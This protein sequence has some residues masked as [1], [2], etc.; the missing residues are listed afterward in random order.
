MRVPLATLEPLIQS[1]EVV[2]VTAEGGR[3]PENP[4]IQAA[5]GRFALRDPVV[6]DD[7]LDGG[8]FPLKR[9]PEPRSIIN[10][11][12]A[13]ARASGGQCCAQSSRPSADNQYVAMLVALIVTI[14]I[15]SFGAVPSPAA[16]R[17][18]GSNQL[19]PGHMNVL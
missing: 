19:Q 3:P 16:R 8:R 17:M 7:S 5:E 12:H 14:G 15:R 10:Q 6:R 9:T 13:C 1:H 18:S 11:H 2:V 4:D